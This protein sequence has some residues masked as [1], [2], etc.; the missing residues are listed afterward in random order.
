M[1]ENILLSKIVA[2]PGEGTWSQAYSTLNLY[3]VLSVKSEKPEVGIVTEGKELFEKIQRE[4]FSLDQKNLKNIKEAVD[5]AL[6]TLEDKSRIS[7]ILATIINNVLYLVITSQGKVILKRGGKVGTVAEGEVGQTF[8]FSGE[9][10]P[11][12]II[13]LETGDFAEK[14]PVSKLA[15]LLDSLEVAEISENL[16]PLI[17]ENP[18][19]TEAAIILQYKTLVS[20]EEPALAVPTEAVEKMPEEKKT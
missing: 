5:Q 20:Q 15:E 6:A 16:A 8:A 19:G 4:Y 11:N 13:I 9:I 17:H 7:V 10:S 12:D 3:I 2:N 1:D 18:L 14:I